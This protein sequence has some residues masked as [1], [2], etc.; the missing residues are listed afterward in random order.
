MA[1]PRPGPALVEQPRRSPRTKPR[2][3]SLATMPNAPCSRS[4]C[5]RSA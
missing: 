4:D 5:V 2:S 1:P 3:P